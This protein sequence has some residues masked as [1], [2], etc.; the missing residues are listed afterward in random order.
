MFGAFIGVIKRAFL[1]NAAVVAHVAGIIGG[2]FILTSPMFTSCFFLFPPEFS[3][4]CF[5]GRTVSETLIATNQIQI[6]Y[7]ILFPVQV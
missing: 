4:N 3:F 1:V 2:N 5:E 7:Y 6:F